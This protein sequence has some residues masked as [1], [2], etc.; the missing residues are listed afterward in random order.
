MA[1]TKAHYKLT[2]DMRAENFEQIK[3]ENEKFV[4]T[5]KPNFLPFMA[6]LIPI[7]IFAIIWGSFDFFFFIKPMLLDKEHS[8]SVDTFTIAFFGFHLIPVWIALI[9]LF[10]QPLNHKKT[11]YALTDQRIL[12]RSGVIGTDYKSYSLKSISDLNVNV[13]I[14]DNANNTGTIS[15]CTG[16]FDSNGK[17]EKG[18]LIGIQ[19]PYEIFKLIQQT[20]N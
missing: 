17:A 1:T 12:I 15:F 11:F 19:K 4:W 2:N 8:S 13:G 16:H 6:S 3:T 7:F 9:S 10:Y 5:D 20:I 18:K 14:L